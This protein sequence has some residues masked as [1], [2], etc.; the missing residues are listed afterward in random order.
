MLAIIASVVVLL[1][2]YILPNLPSILTRQSW[3][4]R[5]VTWMGKRTWIPCIEGRIW[6][7]WAPIPV[8]PN[9][10]EVRPEI[11]DD[12]GEVNQPTALDY[13]CSFGQ[14]M[15]GCRLQRLSPQVL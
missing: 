7:L 12:V 6:G 14:S 8:S 9:S 10:E 13:D 15:S 2:G 11:P 3:L 1:V 4:N 5:P